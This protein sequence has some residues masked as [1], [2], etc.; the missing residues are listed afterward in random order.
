MFEYELGLESRL[1]H[2]PALEDRGEMIAVY[3]LYKLSN[4]GYGFEVLSKDDVIQ[5]AERFS[6]G[7]NSSYSPWKTDFEAM[8]MNTAIKR[9]LKFAP[10]KTESLR[11]IASDETIKHEIGVDMT[12]INGDDVIDEVPQS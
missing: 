1:Y 3:A 12:E 11:A 7:I 8:A 9:V 10:L 5:H 2:K 4:G 6:Q